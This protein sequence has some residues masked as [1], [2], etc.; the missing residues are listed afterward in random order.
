M[1]SATD[2]HHQQSVIMESVDSSTII[3]AQL[4]PS[5]LD[6]TLLTDTEPHIY[7]E[8]EIA[9]DYFQ[10]DESVSTSSSKNKPG[11]SSKEAEINEDVR[12]EKAAPKVTNDCEN[13]KYIL[14]INL[15]KDFKHYSLISKRLLLEQNQPVVTL[16]AC[17]RAVSRMMKVSSILSEFLPNLH[18]VSTIK[19]AKCRT[20]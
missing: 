6:M 2:H 9:Q 14:N 10:I 18:K 12:K 13:L 15:E 1:Q 20:C 11:H 7:H 8:Q 16:T 19:L 5:Q 3:H 4:S 17:G